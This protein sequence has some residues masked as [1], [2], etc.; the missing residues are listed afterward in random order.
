MI[1]KKPSHL[2]LSF[3]A[4]LIGASQA[5]SQ[6]VPDITCKDTLTSGQICPAILPNGYLGEPYNQTVTIIP[7]SSALINEFPLTIVKIK[8]DTIANIP[9]GISYAINATELYPD[10]AYC[11]LI[12]GTPSAIGEF[13]ISITVIPYVDV[14]GSIIEGPPVVDDTSVVVY[15]YDKN[16]VKE[17]NLGEFHVIGNVPNP[18]TE[19]MK[20]GFVSIEFSTVSL[21]V[22]NLTG[23]PVF[24]ETVKAVPGTNY[25]NFTGENLR[26]GCYLYSIGNSQKTY[27][28][29]LIKAN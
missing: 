15:V 20:L 13:R 5:F 11:V 1:M 26:P 16:G 23:I 3:M 19:A 14:L 10:T 29:K 4:V 24:A 9:P 6:C 18:F 25:F 7:P 12:S 8:I 22:Y 27:T 28:G 17:E 2:L 21:T